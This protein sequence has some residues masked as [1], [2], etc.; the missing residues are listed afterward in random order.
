MFQ[1]PHQAVNQDKVKRTG[2]Y[3]KAGSLEA[4]KTLKYEVAPY[5]ELNKDIANV[6]YKGPSEKRETSSLI[7]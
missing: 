3:G 7:R 2:P 4:L 5:A 1:V 6:L